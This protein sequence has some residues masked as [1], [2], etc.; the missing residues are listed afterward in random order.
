MSLPHLPEPIL[1]VA[2]DLDGLIVNTEHV[3]HLAVGELVDTRGLTMPP[4]MQK[5]MMGKR[6]QDSYAVMKAMLGV[7]ETPD[8]LH[9]ETEERFFRL[10]DRHLEL[11]PGVVDLL[12]RIEELGLPRAVATSSPRDYLDDILA[13]FGLSDRFDFS[14]TA[15]DVTNGKPAPEIYLTAARQHSIRPRRM[16]VF[17]DSENGTRSG[18]A[19]GAFVVSVPHDHSREHDFS[20][21]RYVADTVADPGVR[22]ILNA[23]R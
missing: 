19:A 2:F 4:G 5:A 15:E 8:Q 10:L 22:S 9:R 21:A 18:V 11:M 6:P 17:E 23:G 20:G 1:A 12:D 14:L 13:R 7:A 3:F 16:L